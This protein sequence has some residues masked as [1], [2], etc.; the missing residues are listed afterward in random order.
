M[1]RITR[2]NTRGHPFQGA[3]GI[4]I[5]FVG[6]TGLRYPARYSLLTFVW[7]GLMHSSTRPKTLI[8]TVTAKHT[9]EEEQRIKERAD[10]AGLTVSEWARQTHLEAL[11]VSP[12]TRL[13]LSELLG[14]RRMFLALQ[15]D[16][17]HGHEVT[18]ERLRTVMDEA[19]KTKFEMADKRISALRDRG[20][21]LP[22]TTPSGEAVQ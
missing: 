16:A 4:L 18:P 2:S 7:G 5:A 21:N 10:A 8:A 13:I 11:S 22:Q 3:I 19:E 1:L 17:V 14:L 20:K 15:V 12:E 6:V 9:V